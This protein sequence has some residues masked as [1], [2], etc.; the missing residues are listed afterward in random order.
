MQSFR[1]RWEIQKNWQFIFPVLGVISLIFSGY[2]LSKLILSG[3]AP[4]NMLLLVFL[5]LLISYGLLNITLRIFKKLE[6]KWQVAYRWELIAIFIVF[7]ITG[8]TASKLSGPFLELIGLAEITH[9][10]FLFWV[11]RILLIFPFYQILLIIFG[12]LFGQF[13][14]FWAFEKKMLKRMGFKRL[15]KD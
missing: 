9:N 6:P 11:I 4:D 3:F 8:S 13:T 12:W 7:A 5:T 15:F 10:K 1:E 14:F 2:V